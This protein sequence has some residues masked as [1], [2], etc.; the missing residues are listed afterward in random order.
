MTTS[1]PY[2][3]NGVTIEEEHTPTFWVKG[4]GD[5]PRTDVMGAVTNLTFPSGVSDT[6]SVLHDTKRSITLSGS[7]YLLQLPKPQ[8]FPA[9]RGAAWTAEIWQQAKTAQDRT[10]HYVYFGGC[11]DTQLQFGMQNIIPK[12]KF[13]ANWHHFSVVCTGD[14]FVYY[15]D[16]TEYY[17]ESRPNTQLSDRR[18]LVG[19]NGTYTNFWFHDWKV[20]I[21][22][23]KYTENFIP[24]I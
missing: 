4:Y 6:N 14:A 19:A 8:I 13:D 17:R 3:V 22:L 1:M 7:S 11:V 15:V 24:T 9:A 21:G 5:S 2:L 12:E 23:A 10:P 18:F 20:Y 16:G